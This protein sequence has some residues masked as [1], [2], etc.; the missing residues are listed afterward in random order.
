MVISISVADKYLVIPAGA[1]TRCDGPDE[2]ISGGGRCWKDRNLGASQ[3]AKNLTDQLAFGDYYQ[4]G[5]PR[6]GHQH[7]N[8]AY[9]SENSFYNDPEHGDFIL[10]S[11]LPNDWRD[12]QNV[13]LWQGLGGV[14]N[15]CPQGFKIPTAAEWNVEIASWSDKTPNGAYTS[16]LKLVMAGWRDKDFGSFYGIGTHGQYWS[17]TVDDIYSQYLYIAN[18][19]VVMSSD[20][21]AYG[22]NVR[23]IKD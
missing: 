4:W 8:S 23:C 16:P 21:R 20:Y 22:H 12:S 5:R 18:D 15:P 7:W 17:S 6:D 9:T 3:V 1:N 19:G 14:N 10:E 2:V 13:I 11:F